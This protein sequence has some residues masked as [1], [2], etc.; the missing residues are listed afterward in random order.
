MRFARPFLLLTGLLSYGLTQAQYDFS[1][2][3]QLLERHQRDLGNNVVTLVYKDGQIIYKK[4]QGHFTSE[5]Q[6]PIASC[7]KWLTAGLAMTFVDEGKLSLDDTLGKYLPVFTRYGKGSI[8]IRDCMSHMTG[9]QSE[10]LTLI[11]LAK[12]IRK[13]R[14]LGSLK[15]EVDDIAMH[16]P[17]EAAPGSE[18]RY[19]SLGLNILGHVLEVIG[20]KDFETLFR[21]RIARPLEMG[22]TTFAKGR[23]PV[24]PSGGAYSTAMDYMH[25]LEMIL[26]K[27]VYKGKRILSEASV[28]AMQQVQTNPA[29]IKY[30]PATAKGYNYAL[31]EWVGETDAKGH[32]I[33]VTS[34][35]LFGTWPLVD[36]CRGYAVIIFVKNLLREKRKDISMGVVKA[37]NEQMGVACD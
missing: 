26:Q 30:A 11:T 16:T 28:A 23:G 19:S 8:T 29:N 14:K 21:E 31:G 22:H 33:E 24:N 27:G 32:A 35:G 7:S 15:A 20:G 1:E 34:P 2:V 25:F 18:F 6:D 3:D 10:P 17:V 5:T 12:E 13:D 36:N 37:I 9:L 4:E